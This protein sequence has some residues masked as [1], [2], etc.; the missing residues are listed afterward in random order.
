MKKILILAPI[1]SSLL[2]FRGDLIQDLKKNNCEVIT[3]SPKPSK[4]YFKIL[5]QKKIVNFSINF[6]RNKVNPFND[7][8]LLFKLIRLFK[9]QSPDIIFSYAIK[10]VIWGGIAARFCKKNFYALI[11]GLGYVFHGSTPKRKFIKSL[12]IYLYRF[13]LI[14]SKAV[15]FQNID[16]LNFFVEKG[17][18]P[19][20]KAYLVNGS[21]VDIKKFKVAPLPKSSINFLCISRL[22][23]EKGLREY[24]AAAKVVKTKF[25]NVIFSLVGPED[26]SEDG[27][28]LKEVNTWSNHIEYKGASE[29]V[30]PFIQNSHVYILPSYHEGLPRSTLEAMSMGRP[31][32]TSDAPGCKETVKNGINGYKVSIGS[33]DEL[34]EKIIWFI[35]HPEKIKPMGIESR[36]LVEEK[37]EV[38]KINSKMLKILGIN[39]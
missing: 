17:I 30:R 32:I 27:I 38:N 31:I 15:I 16:N 34:V 37:F 11:T 25:P 5:R 22:L 29:D 35:K 19:R 13:A 39:D 3:I 14:N 21:G 8:I 7:I 10:P 12:V 1:A 18:I 6:K 26:T 2:N 33:V 20:S 4:E 9:K 24:A 36:R 23:T 28:D